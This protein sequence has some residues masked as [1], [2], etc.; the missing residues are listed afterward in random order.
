[1]KISKYISQLNL[2]TL[3]NIRGAF[4]KISVNI[5]GIQFFAK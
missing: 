4:R 2:N 5:G 3:F 1:M